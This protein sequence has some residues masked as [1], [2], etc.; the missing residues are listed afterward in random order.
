VN[1]IFMLEGELSLVTKLVPSLTTLDYAWARFSNL[2]NRS[3]DHAA[4]FDGTKLEDKHI[5]RQAIECNDRTCRRRISSKLNHPTEPSD[6]QPFASNPG[7][8]F[9]IVL[10]KF[11]P[12][13]GKTVIVFA[14]FVRIDEIARAQVNLCR[15][16]T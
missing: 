4:E 15:R 12:R 6:S 11:D 14:Q 2:R 5:K 13:I 8:I 7:L 1:P 3:R 10:P 16:P 9:T